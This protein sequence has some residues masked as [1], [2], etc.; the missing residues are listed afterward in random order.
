MN[1]FNRF[2]LISVLVAVAFTSTCTSTKEVTAGDVRARVADRVRE[3]VSFTTVDGVRHEFERGGEVRG[4]ELLLY[5][6]QA[7]GERADRSISSSDPDA[8]AWEYHLPLKQILG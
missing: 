3:V 2:H 5:R 1:P 7:P 4:E 8:P 6:K